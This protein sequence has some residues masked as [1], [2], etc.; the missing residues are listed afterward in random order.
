MAV[1][2]R[3]LGMMLGVFL[4]GLFCGTWPAYAAGEYSVQDQGWRLVELEG[5]RYVELSALVSNQSKEPLTYE[6]RFI[7]EVQIE[8][9]KV[10]ETA[11]PAVPAAEATAPA[12][13]KWSLTKTISVRGGPL[14][15]GSSEAV[16]T[17][18]LYGELELG[19]VYRF[20]VELVNAS[21]GALLAGATLTAAKAAAAAAAGVT[22]QAAALGAAAVVVATGALGGG[23][24]HPAPFS[25]SGSGTMSGQHESHRESEA[26]V[27]HG[28][29]T[30]DVT[31]PQGHLLLDY[32]YDTQGPSAESLTA[33]ATATGTLTRADSST[34]AVEVT[35]ATAQITQPGTRQQVGQVI[36][37]TGATGTGTFSGTVGGSPW[38]GVLT[39]TEGVMTLDLDTN[40]GTHQFQIRFTASQ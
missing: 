2:V 4:A 12:E 38:T 29:G 10:K 9:A 40:T 3:W 1:R 36:T 34:L 21:T 33:A 5:K 15:A 18:F 27:E 35:S 22:A 24:E 26:W 16:K 14:A 31:C 7:V 32:T 30:I 28:S 39:L 37:R 25:V 17:T 23:E 20:R 8:E 19:K 6:V 13:P 11:E